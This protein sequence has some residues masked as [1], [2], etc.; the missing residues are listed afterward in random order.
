M[1]S[2]AIELV[3]DKVAKEMDDIKVTLTWTINT[4]TPEN[5]LA[6]GI[7]A[8]IGP[9]VDNSAPILGHLLRVAAEA[10]RFEGEQ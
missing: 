7:D 1:E 9:G 3:S 4:T 8:F 5:L 6:W 10:K 2:Q